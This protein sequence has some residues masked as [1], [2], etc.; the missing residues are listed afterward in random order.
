MSTVHQRLLTVARQACRSMLGSCRGIACVNMPPECC[1][2]FDDALPHADLHARVPKL[3]RLLQ[4]GDLVVLQHIVLG[5]HLRNTA[6]LTVR[7]CYLRR[8]RRG[9]LL[10]EWCTAPGRLAWECLSGQ[11][12]FVGRSISFSIAVLG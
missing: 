3:L 6:G 7:Y 2:T 11:L 10:S 12:Y 9:A 1:R 4:V 8:S 5:E